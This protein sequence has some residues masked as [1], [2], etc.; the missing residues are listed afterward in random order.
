MITFVGGVALG[1]MWG[2]LVVGMCRPGQHP[3][4]S[5]LVCGAAT[6]VVSVEVLAM[7]N[8]MAVA[9]FLGGVALSAALHL[10]WLHELRERVGS[11]AR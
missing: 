11:G 10:G 2:W 4:R 8:E 5:W 6:A 1:L 7:A 9:L 3:A